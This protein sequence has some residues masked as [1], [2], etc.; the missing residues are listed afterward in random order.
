MPDTHASTSKPPSKPSE[1][2]MFDRRWKPPVILYQKLP[3]ESKT[4]LACTCHDIVLE[5]LKELRVSYQE[6]LMKVQ[7]MEDRYGSSCWRVDEA[8][9]DKCGT[10][11]E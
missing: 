4:A 6:L 11:K 5:E 7:L 2:S 8:D 10:E 9:Y 1:P 3:H